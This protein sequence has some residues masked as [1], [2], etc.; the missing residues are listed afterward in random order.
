MLPLYPDLTIRAMELAPA[1]LCSDRPN[2]IRDLRRWPI[3]SG[4]I[5]GGSPALH[6]TARYFGSRGLLCLFPATINKEEKG[7]QTC[8][9]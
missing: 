6:V 7:R 3:E 2:F 8:E 1:A 5:A 4:N 9:K